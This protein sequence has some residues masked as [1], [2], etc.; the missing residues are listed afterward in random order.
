VLAL[1]FGI[2]LG[3]IARGPNV[4]RVDV[5]TTDAIQRMRGSAFPVLADLG[6]L[7][8]S[9]IWAGIA[10]AFVMAV[11]IALRARAELVFFAVL[12]ALRLAG[13]QLKPIFA[14]PRPTDDLVTIVG[15]WHGSGYP[16][17]HALTASTMT[18]GL[19]VIA[20]RRIPSRGWAVVTIAL[21]GAV[22]LVIG[23]A[24]VW[25]GAHWATDVLGGYAFGTAIVA[26]ATLVLRWLAEREAIDTD[27]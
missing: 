19:A 3:I 24:R 20:W 12:M 4:L 16:S 8:G 23:W 6:N 14:S 27:L 11:A 26:T 13:T 7:L 22:A 17:G 1:A 5:E 10:I 15:T 25:T 18:L 2:G 9:T 21:L